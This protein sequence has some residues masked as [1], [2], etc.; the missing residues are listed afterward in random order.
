MQSPFPGLTANFDAAKSAALAISL[1]DWRDCGKAYAAE[2]T[3]T[4]A[5]LA[6]ALSQ[7]G[8]PIFATAKGATRS[9]QFAI[10]AAAFGGGQTAAKRLRA[11]NILTCGIGL[12]LAPVEGDMNGLRIGT[13]E[14]VRWGMTARDMPALAKLVARGLK[15]Q[16]TAAVA[17]DV[18]AFRRDFKRLQ[19]IR[20]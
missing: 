17:A 9:H 16:D 14:I 4:A 10:E 19:F 2:M 3:A 15:D 8:L 12:P 20:D 13:P 5:S 18:T 6:E 1:L 11:A 7:E